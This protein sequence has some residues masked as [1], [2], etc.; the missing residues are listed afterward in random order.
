M[1]N[2]Q[3]Q[4]KIAGQIKTSGWP[5]PARCITK[6]PAL[7]DYLRLPGQNLYPKFSRVK[8]KYAFAPIASLS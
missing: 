8:P 5:A 7:R 3:V 4:G 2:P 1:E 6:P